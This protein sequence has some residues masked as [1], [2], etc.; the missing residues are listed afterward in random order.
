[1]H[2]TIPH[3]SPSHDACSSQLHM[4]ICRCVA[5][6]QKAAME[7]RDAIAASLTGSDM[8]FVTVSVARLQ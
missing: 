2:F 6:L 5:Q 8:V 1:M 3:H 4:Q 7:S